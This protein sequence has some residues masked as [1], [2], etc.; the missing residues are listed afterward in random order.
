MGRKKFEA[1]EVVFMST[2]RCVSALMVCSRACRVASFRG[3]FGGVHG[4]LLE[5]VVVDRVVYVPILGDDN[6]DELRQSH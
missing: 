5:V 6:S 1:N 3:D 4:A 2:G